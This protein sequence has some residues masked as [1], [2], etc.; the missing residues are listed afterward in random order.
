MPG[1]ISCATSRIRVHTVTG[2]E[3]KV[4]DWCWAKFA[5][6]SRSR[7]FVI[8]QS[9]V[10][11]TCSWTSRLFSHL[12]EFPARCDVALVQGDLH[13][14]FAAL[15]ST[16]NCT[17]HSLT[18]SVSRYHVADDDA[19][20]DDDQIKSNQSKP[21]PWIGRVLG[22]KTLPETKFKKIAQIILENSRFSFRNLF[23]KKKKIFTAT[24]ECSE[25]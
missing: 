24:R 22:V 14:V 5:Y 2:L 19:A 12:S 17:L 15:C 4:A 13:T 3:L 7:R 20:A 16:L 21:R 18:H 6:T 9:F 23:N 11:V 1:G 10:S 25:L 8:L